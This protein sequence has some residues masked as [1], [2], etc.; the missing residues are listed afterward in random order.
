MANMEDKVC[1]NHTDTQATS[2]CTNCF[3]PICNECITSAYGADFCCQS[4]AEKHK[5]S[6]DNL[7]AF[8][9][10]SKSG[11]PLKKIVFVAIIAAIA[12][13]AWENKEQVKETVDKVKQEIPK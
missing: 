8:K 7:N 4:C 10:K 13:F 11:S 9:E 5:R 12:Y 3:K 6:D 2:R 1:L